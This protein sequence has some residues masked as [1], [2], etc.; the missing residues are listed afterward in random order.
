[1]SDGTRDFAL[2]IFSSLFFVYGFMLF[3]PADPGRFVIPYFIAS[4][5]IA[6]LVQKLFIK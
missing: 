3:S 2:E 6:G 4:A 1:M 5:A